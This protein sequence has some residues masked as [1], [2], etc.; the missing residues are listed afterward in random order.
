MTSPRKIVVRAAVAL[1]AVGASTA[2]GQEPPQPPTAPARPLLK[3]LNEETQSLYREVQAGVCRVQL[4]P[5]RWA[6]G[7]LVEQVN[8][9]IKWAD[10]LDPAVREKLEDEQRAAR[11]GVYRR[12][13]RV[14]RRGDDAIRDP[15]CP[16]PAATAATRPGRDAVSRR[17]VVPLARRGR[18]ARLPPERE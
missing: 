12:L 7:P 6:G 3:Q 10:Q 16:D 1:L 13:S 8:P 17:R 18:H 9:A 2:R 14:P 15:A 11:R 5:P 4:P